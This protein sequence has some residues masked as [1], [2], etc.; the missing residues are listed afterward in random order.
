LIQNDSSEHLLAKK[1]SLQNLYLKI[2]DIKK[3]F[4]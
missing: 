4:T 2:I 1:N 3:S